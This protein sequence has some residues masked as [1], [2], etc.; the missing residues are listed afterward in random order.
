MVLLLLVRLLRL[1][2]ASALCR[3]TA[4]DCLLTAG[5]PSPPAAAPGRAAAALLVL[6]TGAGGRDEGP[7]LGTLAFS[8]FALTP[9]SLLCQYYYLYNGK[10][11]DFRT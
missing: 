2:S 1:V 5:P 9:A 11:M 8:A 3:R 4:A 7:E 10:N 6:D